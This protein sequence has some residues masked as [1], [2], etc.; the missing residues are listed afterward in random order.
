MPRTN[1]PQPTP[2]NLHQ[3]MNEAH[4]EARNAPADDRRTH[5]EVVQSLL[6]ELDKCV[7]FPNA[8]VKDNREHKLQ[9]QTVDVSAHDFQTLKLIDKLNQITRAHLSKGAGSGSILPERF[10]SRGIAASLDD[11]LD[12]RNLT[13]AGL[14]TEAAVVQAGS[15]RPTVQFARALAASL[16]N[17]MLSRMGIQLD[18]KTLAIYVVDDKRS[19]QTYM[20]VDNEQQHFSNVPGA[21]RTQ[22]PAITQRIGSP[23]NQKR[24]WAFDPH[25]PYTMPARLDQARYHDGRAV[26]AVQLGS[27]TSARLGLDLGHAQA[28]R[29]SVIDNLELGAG[30]IEHA[31]VDIFSRHKKIHSKFVDGVMKEQGVAHHAAVDKNKLADQELSKFEEKVRGIEQESRTGMVKHDYKHGWYSEKKNPLSTPVN[32]A[33]A[34]RN[35][36]T[37][38]IFTPTVAVHY[39]EDMERKR[40]AHDR[41]ERTRPGGAKLMTSSKFDIHPSVEAIEQMP[42]LH[43]LAGARAMDLSENTIHPGHLE[44]FANA[45]LSMNDWI[46]RMTDELPDEAI[47]RIRSVGLADEVLE[48]LNQVR[49]NLSHLLNKLEDFQSTYRGRLDD[50]QRQMLSSL[51]NALGNGAHDAK[52]CDLIDAFR[53]GTL[54][55]TATAALAST[56]RDMTTYVTDLGRTLNA[57]EGD[58]DE[59]LAR[60]TPA[61]PQGTDAGGRLGALRKRWD[62][63]AD[64]VGQLKAEIDNGGD[65]AAQTA[66]A[67]LQRRFTEGRDNFGTK[68]W[69]IDLNT[70]LDEMERAANSMMD[71]GN[72][73]YAW[74]DQNT[75]RNEALLSLKTASD[76]LF[77]Q[78]HTFAGT[79]DDR[80][81]AQVQNAIT[82]LQRRLSE[83]PLSRLDN[84]QVQPPAYPY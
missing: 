14:A 40:W 47:A 60:S 83:G 2:P 80:Y 58:I 68:I 77:G 82:A 54:V 50:G 21:D 12:Q 64:L 72:P 71:S 1:L 36:Q 30:G 6:N 29:E 33:T 67:G 19:G 44:E 79:A 31:M 56:Q 55:Q 39:L 46:N 17:D 4:R 45:Y 8:M 23:G 34:Y 32:P 78:F 65:V 41:W 66:V 20:V 18:P 49:D 61:D 48:S 69:L 16:D 25:Q 42:F 35:E 27:P 62:E 73:T 7:P 28:V 5:K 10:A 13:D 11:F 43:A 3:S 24:L 84:V 57:I 51:R 15:A 75:R 26:S 81:D 37:G 59:M 52:V 22:L 74:D 9:P 70:K 38:E 63:L 76:N 53:S